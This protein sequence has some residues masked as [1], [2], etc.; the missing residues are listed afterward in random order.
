[1]IAE[2][3]ANKGSSCNMSSSDIEEQLG[4]ALIDFA[5]N[6]IFPEEAVS[7][8]YVHDSAL[9]AALIA[10]N[11]AKIALEVWLLHSGLGLASRRPTSIPL[12]SVRR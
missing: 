10:L 12:F 9:P 1:M 3:A 4:P 11:D 5:T 6:G 2:G 7:A 8:A